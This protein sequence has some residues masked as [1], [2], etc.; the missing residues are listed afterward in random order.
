MAAPKTWWIVG[1]VALLAGTGANAAVVRPVLVLHVD[2]RAGVPARDLAAAKIV[3][4]R[5]FQAAGVDLRW[6]TGRFPLSLLRPAAELGD[7]DHAA[8]LLIN[9]DDEATRGMTGC[10]L[11][12]AA[13]R[14]AVAYAFYNR[15]SEES[16]RRSASLP[17]VL[18]RVIAHEIGHLLL[19]RNSHSSDGIMRADLDVGYSNPDL[20]T[21]VQAET[22][23]AWL[24]MK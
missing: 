14:H 6:T 12:F 5:T 19:P 7:A 24:A 10:I 3:V 23:R 13:P 15:V 20:F 4:E 8:V 22:I 21:D 2:D 16:E 18:G 11:G 17:L 1:M 9:V